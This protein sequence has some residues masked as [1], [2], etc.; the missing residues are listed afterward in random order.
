MRTTNDTV[1][2]GNPCKVLRTINEHDM[3]YYYKDREISPEDLDEE[4]RLR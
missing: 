2:V 4:A 1:A 3:R